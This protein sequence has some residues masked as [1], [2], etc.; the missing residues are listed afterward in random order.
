LVG[1]L[2]GYPPPALCTLAATSR[3]LQEDADV[4]FSGLNDPVTHPCRRLTQMK[5]HRFPRLLKT[6]ELV[7][8]PEFGVDPVTSILT[9]ICRLAKGAR[10]PE[11]GLRTSAS[12]EIGYVIT[13]RLRID[14]ASSSHEASAG[15]ALTT[16]PAEP[17]STTA[18]DDSEIFF[19]LLDPS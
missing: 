16:S 14:T 1:F 15:E 18:L 10:S 19:V 8:V 9:G 7:S 12:H 4:S 3:V 2:L 6:Y 5:V 11:V 13:G 17:H